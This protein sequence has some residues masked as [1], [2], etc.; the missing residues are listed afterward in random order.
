MPAMVG[1]RR[2]GVDVG[3]TKLLAVVLDAE[4]AI[5][6][7]RRVPTPRSGPAIVDHIARMASESEATAV[8]LGVAG[9]LDLDGV[10]RVGAN[11]P[12]V[13]DFPFAVALRDALPGLPVAVDNDAN[14]ALRAEHAFGAA[15]G[16]RDAVLVTFGT[17]IGGAVLSGGSLRRG[18]NG[19]AGEPGHMVVDP[20]G[21]ACPCGR[22]GCWERY[23]SGAGLARLGAAARGEEVTLAAA[24]GD[25]RAIAVFEEVGWWAALGIAN[26]VAL[27]DPELVVIGGG[28][29]EAGEL[30]MGPVRRQYE[31]IGVAANVRIEPAALG[32]RAGAVGAALLAAR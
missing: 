5:V 32:E 10:L 11:L 9:L 14:C 28:M 20:S 12:G 18:A 6:G 3:G 30:L 16:A 31:G 23:A 7:E 2:L 21:P 15:V 8:G 27:L 17:G 26:I 25:E 24:A 1:E 22:K 19:F 4:G 13:V 29:V